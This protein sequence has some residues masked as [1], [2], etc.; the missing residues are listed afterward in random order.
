VSDAAGPPRDASGARE[1]AVPG[2]TA[3]PR[4]PLGSWGALYA[5]VLAELVLVI[6]LLG[7][8]TRTF[9]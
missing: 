8:L 1:A 4:P 6:V 3:E 2:A 5:V 7:W 9:S